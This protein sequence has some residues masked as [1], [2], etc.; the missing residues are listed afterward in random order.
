MFEVMA[1]MALVA[2]TFV[3]LGVIALTPP[4][5][6]GQPVVHLGVTPSE[7][8]YSAPTAKVVI[9]KSDEHRATLDNLKALTQE[10]QRRE[11]QS[12]RISGKLDLLLDE[13]VKDHGG[14][15]RGHE[16]TAS[17]GR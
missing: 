8:A 2:A 4:P 5:D 16:S 15:E 13:Q 14:T 3:F 12:A 9:V 10:L 6:A 1:K 7:L 17:P 11:E